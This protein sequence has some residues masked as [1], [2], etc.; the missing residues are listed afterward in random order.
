MIEKNENENKLTKREIMIFIASMVLIVFIT[1]ILVNW[2]D[3]KYTISFEMDNN[4]KEVA[5]EYLQTINPPNFTYKYPVTKEQG[6][7]FFFELNNEQYH[8]NFYIEIIGANA[9]TDSIIVQIN[10][11]RHILSVN[12]SISNNHIYIIIHEIF[13]TNI[14]YLSASANIEIG[15]IKNETHDI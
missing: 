13:I 1:I 3:A 5:L 4:T 2:T 7:V 15:E 10:G 6:D 9:Y 12:E 8:H 14:P 11:E